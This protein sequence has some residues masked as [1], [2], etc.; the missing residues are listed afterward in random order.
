[1]GST[2]LRSD[3]KKCSKKQRKISFMGELRASLM[4]SDA[5]GTHIVDVCKKHLIYDV[6]EGGRNGI[7]MSLK[8]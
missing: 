3:D 8:V 5:S 2:W 6:T 1:M 7:I 4:R